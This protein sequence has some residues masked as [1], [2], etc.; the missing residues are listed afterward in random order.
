MDN[1]N[2]GVHSYQ[3]T[4]NTV[5][6]KTVND[7][8]HRKSLGGCRQRNT[9]RAGRRD[10]HTETP[11]ESA[12]TPEALQVVNGRSGD[13]GAQVV[14]VGLAGENKKCMV[15]EVVLQTREQTMCPAC[16]RSPKRARLPAYARS[17]FAQS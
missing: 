6:G 9:G 2:T 15:F 11:T 1:I 12:S 3:N 17:I 13:D 10:S 8:M 7:N 14:P 4:R 16:A 5:L